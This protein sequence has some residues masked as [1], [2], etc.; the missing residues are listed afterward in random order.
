MLLF[1]KQKK[2][3]LLEIENV[4]VIFYIL[5]EYL[6]AKVEETSPKIEQDK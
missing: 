1:K 4:I 2:K 3:K 5:V 6:E